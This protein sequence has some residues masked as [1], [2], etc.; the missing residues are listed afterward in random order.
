MDS[1][2]N[3]ELTLDGGDHSVEVIGPILKWEAQ[4]VGAIV[5][6]FIVQRVPGGLVVAGGI[7]EKY[8]NPTPGHVW[9]SAPGNTQDWDADAVVN[10]ALPGLSPGPA[11]AYAHARIEDATGQLKPFNWTV[12]ILLEH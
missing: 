12:H 9:V 11:V 8:L 10:A 4:E 3:D 1:R 6:V 5:A 2:I 7:S